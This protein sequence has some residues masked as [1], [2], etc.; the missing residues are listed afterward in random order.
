MM[1]PSL[2]QIVCLCIGYLCSTAFAA[3]APHATALQITAT[4]A[5]GS[6]AILA[7]DISKPVLRASVGVKVNGKWLHAI[8]YPKHVIGTE[9]AVG[10]LGAVKVTTIR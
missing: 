5:D 4:A 10:E 6:Y 9:N 1:Q 3:A 8:D 2:C 7:A